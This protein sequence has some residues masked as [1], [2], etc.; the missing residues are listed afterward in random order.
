MKELKTEKNGLDRSEA[1]AR[2]S[3][4]GKNRLTKKKQ[5]NVASRFFSALADPMTLILLIAAVISFFSSKLSGEGV[6]DSMMILAIVG[7]NGVISVIQEHRADKALEA[8][9]KMS[10]PLCRVVRNGQKTEVRGEDVVPGDIVVLEKGDVVP[11]DCRLLES[12]GLACDESCLTGESVE[13]QKNVESTVGDGSD[14]CVFG[15][16][17]VV[18]G[19]GVG[20]AVSTGMNTRVGRIAALLESEDEKTPLQKRLA[21]LSVLLG[22]ATVGICVLLMIF[23]VLRGMKL[24]EVFLTGISLSVAAIPEGLPAIVTVVLSV[25]VQT[26]ARKNAIVKRLPAVETLGCADV[27]CSDK[28]GT[29]TC[30]KMTVTET[31]GSISEL[32][33]AFVLCNNRSSPTENALFEYVSPKRSEELQKEFTRVKEVPFDSKK[34]YMITVH[35]SKEGFLSVIKGAPD[36][37]GSFCSEDRELLEKAVAEMTQKG[38]R[39]MGF[40][41]C[42]TKN[43][44]QEPRAI[45]FVPAGVC[46]ISDPPRPEVP[47]AVRLCR[48]AGIKT[49]M[50]TGDHPDTAKAV[51]CSVGIAG[52]DCRVA[53]EN[54]VSSADE[55][56]LCRLVKKC[57]VFARVTPESKLRIVKAFQKNGSIVAM[58]GDGVNDAPA[59]KQADI[60]CAM[61]RG[62][63]EVAR[64]AA[65]MILTDDNFATVV[66]AVREGRGVY[67]NIRR[68]VHFL[69]SC[70]IGELFSVF[71]AILLSFPP[72]LSA[73]Q[74][75]WV[76][77]TTD[78]LPAIA[79]G[80]E[81]TPS[82]VMKEKP[83]PKNASLFSFG[84]G[85]RILLEGLFI[86]G[87]AVL[88]FV[89]GKSMGGTQKGSTMCFFVLAVSQLFHSFNMRSEQSVFSAGKAKNP[90]LT[91]AFF[92][93]LC[94][95][96]L[97]LLI[98]GA[99]E[100]FGVARLSASELGICFCLSALPLVF[101]EIYKMFISKKLF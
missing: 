88:A 87:I 55:R 19:H 51:A 30:N 3:V 60:G 4:Y 85:A 43:M 91:A 79:L 71:L 64:E 18:L 100:L 77:L 69:L 56:E 72:P 5:K 39:V 11:C 96:L 93:C 68:A 40:G 36:V 52:N 53:C 23:S 6:A 94:M 78:S 67:R 34:K 26:M 31:K 98:P 37:I 15:S 76:N 90:F 57:S 28:T 65:D 24:G 16:T 38:L 61:G 32:E 80:L 49:V 25:G 84:E 81:K 14:A 92:C 33:T 89:L 101:C 20:V 70:N 45:K 99:R 47:D 13:V 2:L 54:E 42:R 12:N 58:T 82:Q 62:G 66:S 41:L 97:V 27:I 29:L 95:M 17:S 48:Q 59:L 74:L 63:T 35:K 50:I 8:L 44:P 10:A 83:K 7:A 46:G 9:E 22:K 75:L 1:E 21:S 86:G 73:I